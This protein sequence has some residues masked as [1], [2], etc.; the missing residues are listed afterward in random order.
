MRAKSVFETKTVSECQLCMSWVFA[1]ALHDPTVVSLQ[2][3]KYS[4]CF[5]KRLK[6]IVHKTSRN[7]VNML[8]LSFIS[9]YRFIVCI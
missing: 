2:A 8:V 6:Y 7:E 9:K 5:L 4:Q 3:W 1:G